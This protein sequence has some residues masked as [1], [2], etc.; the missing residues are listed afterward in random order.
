MNSEAGLKGWQYT[1]YTCLIKITVKRKWKY[2]MAGE[3]KMWSNQVFAHLTKC[4]KY[5]FAKNKG[6]VQHMRENKE[7]LTLHQFYYHSKCHARCCGYNRSNGETYCQRHRILLY[8]VPLHDPLLYSKLTEVFLP[9]I[10]K[11]AL[12]TD[13]CL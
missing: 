9:V 5:V 7:A 11:A 2:F 4:L 10:E 12:Y 3:T 6:N 1:N 13:F 8:K